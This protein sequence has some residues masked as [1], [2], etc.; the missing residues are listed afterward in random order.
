MYGLSKYFFQVVDAL[1]I[2]ITSG[3]TAVIRTSAGA[4][5]TVYSD[6]MKATFTNPITAASFAGLTAGTVEF[7]AMPGSTFDIELIDDDGNRVYVN[8]WAGGQ[9][10]IVLDRN[11]IVNNLVFANIAA[12][13]SIPPSSTSEAV[14]ASQA[15]LWGPGLKA[16]DVIRVRGQV[17]VTGYNGTPTLTIKLL[18]GGTTTNTSGELIATIAA[19]SVVTNDLVNFDVDITINAIGSSGKLAAFGVA[20]TK[21]GSTHAMT[22]INKAEGTEDISGAVVPVK[23]TGTFNASH[24]S[25]AAVLEHLNVQLLRRFQ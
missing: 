8:D 18:V 6:G 5:A 19:A 22:L 17:L 11:R 16:G 2:P 15:A 13:D 20:G 14:F 21:L 24:A 7:W 10:R 9:T 4:V 1:G 23:V 25:N 3:I 12:G